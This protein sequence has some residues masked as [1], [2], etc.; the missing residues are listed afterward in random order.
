MGRQRQV[1]TPLA[2][3]GVNK[4]RF[5]GVLAIEAAGGERSTVCASLLRGLLER[6]LEGVR[7]LVSDDHEGTKSATAGE[8][9][10]FG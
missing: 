6:G 8:L 1:L 9:T 7:L 10:G 2:T 5:R 4:A 3:V